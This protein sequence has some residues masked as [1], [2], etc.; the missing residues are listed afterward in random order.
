MNSQ[1]EQ[2]RSRIVW[3]VIVP[4]IGMITLS[5]LWILFF[6]ADN[7]VKYFKFSFLYF[8]EGCLIGF[9][10]SLAGYIFYIVSK[11]TGKFS[12]T[13]ELFEKVLSPSFRILKVTDFIVLSF[14]A[15]FSE[16]VLFRGLLSN[17]IGL[18]FSSLAF[19]LMHFPGRKYWIY[20]VWATLSGALFCWILQATGSLFIPITA[21]T[22][23]N[24]L[25]MILLKRLKPK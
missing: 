19:G 7:I 2:N 23:N 3:S 5:T 13:V 4:Q 9:L 14:V 17:K 25:G 8:V 6:P 20:T 22:V 21:H 11:K 16:E 12:E 18:I 10:L 15:G 24:I 1:Q